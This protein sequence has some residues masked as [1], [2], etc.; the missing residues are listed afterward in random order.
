[1]SKIG[2]IFERLFSILRARR[3]LRELMFWI[4][5]FVHEK[6]FFI[7]LYEL[8][9]LRWFYPNCKELYFLVALTFIYL[10][11]FILQEEDINKVSYYLFTQLRL[12]GRKRNKNPESTVRVEYIANE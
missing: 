6:I 9:I 3:L 7:Y 8:E 2:Y 5:S 10:I 11:F 12:Q 4:F 1:M